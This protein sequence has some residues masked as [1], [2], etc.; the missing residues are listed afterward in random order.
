MVLLTTAATLVMVSLYL[1]WVFGTRHSE[2]EPVEKQRAA[3]AAPWGNDLRILTFYSTAA[4]LA[5]GQKAQLCYG[6]ANAKVVKLDPAVDEVWPS[7]SRC[8]EISPER[9][10]RYTLTAED[11]KGHSVT[12]SV[13]VQ[14]GSAHPAP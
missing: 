5:R 14:V 1:V 7:P 11:A 3:D 6:V 10:T 9:T 13:E 2:N 12:Q 4:A 8:L